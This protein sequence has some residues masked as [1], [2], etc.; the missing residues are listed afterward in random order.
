LRA[1]PEPSDD[2]KLVL[3]E[4]VGSA[5]VFLDHNAARASALDGAALVNLRDSLS[6]LGTF[7]SF[8]CDIRAAV[9]FISER[10]TSLRVG[11]DRARPGHLFLSRLSD[12]GHAGRSTVFV[13][14]LEEGRVF[15]GTVEDPVLL[16]AE[17]KHISEEL[18]TSTDRLD[19]AVFVVAYRMATLGAKHVCLSYSCRDTREFRETFPSW[20]MLNAWRLK[21]GMVGA[22][23]E[24]LTQE[25]GEPASR[26]PRDPAA[27]L[28]E[29]GWWLHQARAAGERMR[30][31]LLAAHPLLAS[32]LEAARQRESSVFTEFDG[33]VPAAGLLLDPA[34]QNHSVSVTTLEG[35][36]ECSFRFF[37]TEGLGLRPLAESSRQTDIWL[38]PLTRGSELHA[39]FATVMRE[40]REAG[41]WPPPGSF[42][43][44]ARELCEMRP[45]E[46]KEELPPPS[47]EV[48]S[49]ESQ[50]LIHDVELFIKEERSIT[51][52]EGI[53]FE[54]TF[55]APSDDA[56][57]LASEQP[58]AIDLG[59]KRILLR[60]RIDRINRL[61]DGSYEIVDYKTGGF[62]RDDW[63]GVFA[64]GTRLQ[65]ALYTIAAT[66]LLGA[67]GSKK[68]VVRRAI[69]RFPTARGGRNFAT[70]TKQQM[71]R[72]S[73][74][75]NDLSEVLSAGTF[76]HAPDED[77]CKWC[78][79]GPAC[80]QNAVEQ[81]EAKL[82]NTSNLML[83]AYR[84][85]QE[86]D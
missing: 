32:G 7:G 70:F 42:A 4:L 52:A 72:L 78:E 26:V 54:V 62:W 8:R 77:S 84:R 20:I 48:F 68:P 64:G 9:R 10:V 67:S 81:A 58:V 13:I 69:Y 33:F 6:E 22:T 21:T 53:A 71:S 39:L 29:T 47:E 15:P 83:D 59:G 11:T 19:E 56:E 43:A 36:G 80:G 46:L 63:G 35:A 31:L 51:D 76:I 75:L 61:R 50:D 34:S 55:G 23:F 73:P 74:V 17:R 82:E 30:P 57:E 24:D 41:K 25:L 16:D 49:R 38:D 60:G 5:V 45:S 66:E 37:L 12:A 1:V 14:G 85:L 40:V 86:Y 79:F 2:G 28:T 44:R 27:A 18:Q 65:H 3:S